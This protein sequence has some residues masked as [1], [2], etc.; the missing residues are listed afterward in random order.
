VVI[1]ANRIVGFIGPDGAG[2]SSEEARARSAV[3]PR[4]AYMPQGLGRNL[5]P[6]LSVHENVDFFGRV[7]GRD[8][9]ERRRGIDDL[10]ASTGLAPSR[11]RAAAKLWRCCRGER[12]AWPLVV[13]PRPPE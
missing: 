8:R 3:Q 13:P 7:F 9:E 2:K 1:P 4:I 5:Y 10:L 12:V 6:T 11:D